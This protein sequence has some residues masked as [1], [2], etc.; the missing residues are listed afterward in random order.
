MEILVVDTA[1]DF[2]PDWLLPCIYWLGF[3]LYYYL[4]YGV[5]QGY[6]FCM[7]G[8]LEEAYSMEQIQGRLRKLIQLLW[9]ADWLLGEAARGMCIDARERSEVVEW[10]HTCMQWEFWGVNAGWSVGSRACTGGDRAGIEQALAVTEQAPTVTE[11]APSQHGSDGSHCRWRSKSRPGRVPFSKWYLNW[12][13]IFLDNNRGVYN[14]YKYA[15][16]AGVQ[17]VQ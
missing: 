8:T 1:A 10:R 12:A 2:P 11:P 3:T 6:F 15:C 14:L 5:L 9:C 13:V 4:F 7:C 17:F 16:R